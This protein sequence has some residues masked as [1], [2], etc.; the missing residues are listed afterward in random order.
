MVP[1]VNPILKFSQNPKK[2]EL[3]IKNSI[4]LLGEIN[5]VID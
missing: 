1:A 3:S 2:L 4:Q 5:L